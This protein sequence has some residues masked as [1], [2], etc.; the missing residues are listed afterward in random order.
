MLLISGSALPLQSRRA[1]LISG[2]LEITRE[3]VNDDGC[4]Y[5]KFSQDLETGEIISTELWRDREALDAHM[6][7]DHTIKFFSRLDGVFA[8]PPVMTELEIN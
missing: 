3:T 6:A 2:A 5:Y 1:E 4:L 7:H 8:E